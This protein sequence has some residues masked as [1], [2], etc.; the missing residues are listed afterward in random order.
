MSLWPPWGR[1]QERRAAERRELE[2]RRR[3]QWESTSRAFARAAACCSLQARWSEPRV[4]PPRYG[5]GPA[6][7]RSGAGIPLT[8]GVCGS[9]AAARRD[10]EEAAARLER[11]RERLERLLSEEREALAAELRERQRGGMRSRELLDGPG[12]CERKVREPTGRAHPECRV[13]SGVS[14]TCGTCWSCH[15]LVS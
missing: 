9:A 7:S 15:R 2:A 13:S 1:G 3:Q 12:Q 8:A 6:G 11:R 10:A 4:P 14:C 5:R